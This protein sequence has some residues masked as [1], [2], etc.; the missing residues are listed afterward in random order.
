[1]TTLIA[2]TLAALVL[3][4]ACLQV[5]S[6]VQSTMLQGAPPQAPD[7]PHDLGHRRD[8]DGDHTQPIARSPRTHPRPLK[9]PAFPGLRTH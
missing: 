3:G 6:R 9:R 7:V 1:M 4:F 2:T 8:R 5:Y